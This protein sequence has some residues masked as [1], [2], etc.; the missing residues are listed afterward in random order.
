MLPTLGPDDYVLVDPSAYNEVTPCAGDVVVARHPYQ[1]FFVIKRIGRVE[2]G[3]VEL[4]G[5]NPRA[6]TDSRA[7][8]QVPLDRVFG[9]VTSRI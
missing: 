3:S 2:T 7:Y 9:R 6:S 1:A 5:D 4:V 8:G